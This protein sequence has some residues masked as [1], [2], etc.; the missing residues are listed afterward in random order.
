MSK[1]P[2]TGARRN[3]G[4]VVLGLACVLLPA[5]PA[6]AEVCDKIRPS[7]SPTD[8]PI[9][10]VGEAVYHSSTG[11]GLVAAVLLVMGLVARHRL[12]R[13][14]SSGG[15]ALMATPLASEWWNM[16]PIYR[17]ALAEGCL[18]PPYVSIAVL[19]AL[20][21]GMFHLAMRP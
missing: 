7:W 13:F 18:G 3:A 15:L 20:S 11:F 14:A 8:G 17:E 9:G 5:A 19:L 16:H 21:V 4:K 6:A 10:A 12:V 1:R 2:S